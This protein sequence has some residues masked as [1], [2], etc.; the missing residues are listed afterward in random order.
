MVTF[1]VIEDESILFVKCFDQ[2][3]I[4]LHIFIIIMFTALFIK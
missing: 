1:E 4:I 2:K 3:K